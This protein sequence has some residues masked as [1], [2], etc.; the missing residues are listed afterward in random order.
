VRQAWSFG[1]HVS[2]PSTRQSVTITSMMDPNTYV[3]AA[4]LNSLRQK[5]KGAWTPEPEFTPFNLSL[6][7][8]APGDGQRPE[9]GRENQVQWQGNVEAFA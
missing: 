4:V 1:S 5:K 6:L 8:H 7:R 9:M 3:L 2:N